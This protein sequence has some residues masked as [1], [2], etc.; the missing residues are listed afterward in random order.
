MLSPLV[1]NAIRERV[2]KGQI[3]LDMARPAPFLGQLLAHQLGGTAA[4][5]PFVL[6][7]VPLAFVVGGLVPPAS[8]P[9]CGW[10]ACA[11]RWNT[12]PISY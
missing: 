8:P 9:V 5:L 6:L 10:R 2:Q 11:G 7:A 4:L 3:A 1:A 12:A